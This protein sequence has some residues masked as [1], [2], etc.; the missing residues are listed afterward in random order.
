MLIF[1]YGTLLSGLPLSYILDN[2]D[3]LGEAIAGGVDLY[4]LGDYP[5]IKKGDGAVIGELY[6]A[7]NAI[8]EMLDT[9]EGYNSNNLNNSLY[10]RSEIKLIIPNISNKVFSYFYN[11]QVNNEMLI[12]NGDYRN[13]LRPRTVT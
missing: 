11:L 9:V 13:F 2:S 8:L 6:Y 12:D 5:G 10:L 4:N 7:N 1:V 3:Y